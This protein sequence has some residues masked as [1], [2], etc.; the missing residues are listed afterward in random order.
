MWRQYAPHSPSFQ[1]L[2]LSMLS[3]LHAFNMTLFPRNPEGFTTR[4]GPFPF[5]KLTGPPLMEPSKITSRMTLPSEWAVRLT[6]PDVHQPFISSQYSYLLVDFQINSK[7]TGQRGTRCHKMLFVQ[8]GLWSV[9]CRVVCFTHISP[10]VTLSVSCR[11]L[12]Y[13]C[14]ASQSRNPQQEGGV[15]IQNAHGGAGTSEE[16][17]HQA[18][19][20]P[21]R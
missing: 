14:R 8:L 5:P 11:Y 21:A 9:K 2:Q 1:S 12:R 20:F 13:H 4:T 3:C 6:F 15:V 7:W 17:G 19:S 16:T 10:N 18:S